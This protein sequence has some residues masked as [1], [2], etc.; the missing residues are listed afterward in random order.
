[1]PIAW[2]REFETF[3]QELNVIEFLEANADDDLDLDE[4]KNVLNVSLYIF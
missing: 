3:I 1:M 2:K 4:L